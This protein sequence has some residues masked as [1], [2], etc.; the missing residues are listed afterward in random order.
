MKKPLYNSTKQ[1][2]MQVLGLFQDLSTKDV[3]VQL[4]CPEIVEDVGKLLEL[5]AL[6]AY[7]Y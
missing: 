7:T 6:W 2:I 1:T 3:C 4:G 5:Y